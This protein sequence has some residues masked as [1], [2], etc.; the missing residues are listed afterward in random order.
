MRDGS[1]LIPQMRPG[2]LLATIGRGLGLLDALGRWG[3]D[4]DP[5]GGKIIWFV[6]TGDDGERAAPVP[7]GLVMPRDR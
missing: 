6:P 5:S 3:V 1:S 2:D 7:E 4:R